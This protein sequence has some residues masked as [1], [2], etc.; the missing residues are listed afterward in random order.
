MTYGIKRSNYQDLRPNVMKPNPTEHLCHFRMAK[1]LHTK[2]Q[3]QHNSLY[4]PKCSPKPTKKKVPKL[5]SRC[6]DSNDGPITQKETSPRN[7]K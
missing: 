1:S 4:M 7:L 6:D 5:A 3:T 2:V